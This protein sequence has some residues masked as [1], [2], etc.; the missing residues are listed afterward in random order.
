MIHIN[1]SQITSLKK[2]IENLNI[3]KDISGK[4]W[5]AEGTVMA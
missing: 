2:S 1:L 5:G 4:S 3:L